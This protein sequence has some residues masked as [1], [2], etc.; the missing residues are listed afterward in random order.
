MLSWTVTFWR[1]IEIAD[2]YLAVLCAV[3][4]LTLVWNV[5]FCEFWIGMGHG[6][7]ALFWRSSVKTEFTWGLW[8][9]SYISC[10]DPAHLLRS[11]TKPSLKFT[12]GL[13]N[14][15]HLKT[16]KISATMNSSKSFH[17]L[18]FLFVNYILVSCVGLL[19]IL[20]ACQWLLALI[21]P[22]LTPLRIKDKGVCVTVHL[23]IL[24]IIW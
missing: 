23:L 1:N 17:N 24:S 22:S 5:L 3:I 21:M 8:D 9:M 18:Q 13:K 19:P 12:E 10:A 15:A 20:S 11:A 16:I 6:M 4:L 7:Q 14:L 2:N